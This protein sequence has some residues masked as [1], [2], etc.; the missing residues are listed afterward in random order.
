MK[1]IRSDPDPIAIAALKSGQ[2]ENEELFDSHQNLTPPNKIQPH[3]L[4]TNQSYVFN[5]RFVTCGGNLQSSIGQDFQGIAS[6]GVASWEKSSSS[7]VPAGRGY[8]TVP[9]RV[10]A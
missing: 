7:K 10:N 8:G 1:E 3:C 5:G 9:W 2:N 6:L 4:N